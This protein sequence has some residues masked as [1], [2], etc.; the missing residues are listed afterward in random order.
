LAH[1]LREVL[2]AAVVAVEVDMAVQ[3][4][5]MVMEMDLGLTEEDKGVFDC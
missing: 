5:G 4:V 3:V 2:V 1:L